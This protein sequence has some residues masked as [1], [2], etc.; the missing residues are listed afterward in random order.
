MWQ[1]QLPR[2]FEAAEAVKYFDNFASTAWICAITTGRCIY[3][4]SSD[5]FYERISYA[6]IV[7]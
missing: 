7:P 5:A 1:W 4:M 2:D 3:I 6:A